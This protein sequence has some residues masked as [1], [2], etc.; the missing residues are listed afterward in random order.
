MFTFI[1]FILIILSPLKQLD[2]YEYNSLIANQAALIV[3]IENIENIKLSQDVSKWVNLSVRG[4]TKYQESTKLSKVFA[5]II[6]D[7]DNKK[8]ISIDDAMDQLSKETQETLNNRLD[9]WNEWMI[10]LEK[11]FIKL[12]GKNQ[13]STL[14]QFKNVLTE[15]KEG[16]Q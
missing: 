9:A 8:I 12:D 6:K 16:L 1:L 13:L 15:I 4:T 2:G 14:D 3:M 11:E 7:I 5:D 10:L